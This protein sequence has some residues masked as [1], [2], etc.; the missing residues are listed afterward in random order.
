MNKNCSHKSSHLEVSQETMN[1]LHKLAHMCGYK[2]PGKVVDKLVREKM[3][4]LNME[5]EEDEE[6]ECDDV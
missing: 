4:M 1:N 6:E 2:H 5:Q 3:A